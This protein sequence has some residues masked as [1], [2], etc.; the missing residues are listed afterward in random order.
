MEPVEP[1]EASVYLL[2]VQ[3]M[4]QRLVPAKRSDLVHRPCQAVCFLVIAAPRPF[5][6]PDLDIIQAG[7]TGGRFFFAYKVSSPLPPG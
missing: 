6:Y 4:H 3:K 5:G 7:V 1:E 2:S